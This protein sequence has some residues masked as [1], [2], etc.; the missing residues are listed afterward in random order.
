MGEKRHMGMHK[1]SYCQISAPFKIVT[2]KCNKMSSTILEKS[3]NFFLFSQLPAARN[4]RKPK[5]KTCIC[6][7]RRDD[8]GICTRLYFIRSII[9][10]Q[11][12]F[13][14]RLC[15]HSVCAC[16][17]I[18]VFQRRR[19]IVHCRLDILLLVGREPPPLDVGPRPSP[20][21]R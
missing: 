2:F 19:R 6:K 21:C 10:V 15:R 1:P 9:E 11:I 16:V 20:V 8:N 7:R 14:V 5:K 13:Q 12:T 3:D 18:S 4:N 17:C